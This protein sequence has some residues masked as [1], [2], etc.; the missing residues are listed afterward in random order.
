MTR[1]VV[2]RAGKDTR[3]SF[4]ALSGRGCLPVVEDGEAVGNI[5]PCAIKDRE[6]KRY[7][8]VAVSIDCWI[9]SCTVIWYLRRAAGRCYRV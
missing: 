4:T 5:V 1:T 9:L 6:I 8:S 3:D 2:Y 7:I